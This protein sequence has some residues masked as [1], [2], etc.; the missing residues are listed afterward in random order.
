M[1]T[2]TT[3]FRSLS[4]LWVSM[5]CAAATIA[6]EE[7][8]KPAADDPKVVRGP[9]ETPPNADPAWVREHDP[10]FLV[11]GEYA[12]EHG[13]DGGKRKL[14]AQVAAL[15]DGRFHVVAFE[16]GL[17]GAGFDPENGKRLGPELVER[18]ASGAVE[19]TTDAGKRIAIRDGKLTATSA[20][21]KQI[22]V[23]ER[24]VRK[25]K[26]L[27]AKPPEGAGVLFD[28]SNA[29]AWKPI[30]AKPAL[31]SDGLLLRGT[32][33]LPE[34]QSV[35][36]HIEFR[37]PWEPKGRGQGRGN[38]GVYVQGRYEVQV[39]DSFAE[40]PEPGNCGGMYS[41]AAPA[42]NMCYPPLE[43]QTYDIDFTAAEFETVDGKP[44]RVR[45]ARMSV[46]HNG[47]RIHDDVAIGRE[48]TT[49]AP[50]GESPKPGPLFLQDHG[51][52]VVYQNVWVVAK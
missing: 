32:T 8:A 47:V 38:S 21:G 35:K 51:H 34:F 30:G 50:E 9:H 10:D 44:K 6:A 4:A 40:K 22:A 12:G 20:D 41:I 26:T 17:P 39:L 7:P 28:G 42:V 52:W 18:K 29:D 36:I 43:W 33:S 24:V 3:R 31:T 19:G 27:G 5:L 14:G 23:L 11:Q 15:G 2:S 48:R 49:A 37:T 13:T 46:L 45:D 25:S 16:G 1:N